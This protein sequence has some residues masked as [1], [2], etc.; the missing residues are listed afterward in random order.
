MS[1]LLRQGLARHLPPGAPEFLAGV[2]VGVAGA[3]GLGSN[4]AMHLVRSG[5]T[6][7]VLA[8]FDAV[9][10]SNLNRQCYT[11]AQVGRAKVEALAENLRAVNPEL[12]LTLC[13]VRLDGASA[14]AVFGACHAVVEALDD[15]RAKK[16]LAEAVLP[17][18]ALLVAASGIGGFGRA[19][20]I[21]T[22]TLRPN[23][24]LVGDG[25]TACGPGA[26]PLSPTVGVAAA[27]QAD[28]VLAHFLNRFLAGLGPGPTVD[29]A[30]KE[31][32][33]D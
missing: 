10:P 27:M 14:T 7:L 31:N 16:A 29:D 32:P 15:P 11:A 26:P 13:P 1:S 8:D 22:R 30:E 33:H 9:E 18:P 5:F 23:F 19:G 25:C 4:C 21:R 20:G 3:G 12:R 6:R 24:V 17:G 2:A 28:A